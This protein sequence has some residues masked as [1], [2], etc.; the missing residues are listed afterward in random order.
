MNKIKWIF[1][2]VIVL[3]VSGTILIKM[4]KSSQSS[5]K[6]TN[7]GSQEI[8]QVTKVAD[9]FPGFRTVQIGDRTWM[10]ENLNVKTDSSWCY[11]NDEANC[12]KYGRLYTFHDARKACPSGWHL[13]NLRDEKDL[14]RVL[15]EP[16]REKRGIKLAS[17]T[18]GVS[19]FIHNNTVDTTY[20]GTDDLGLS[21]LPGGFSLKKG[22]VFKGIGEESAIWIDSYTSKNTAVTLQIYEHEYTL[23]S[24]HTKNYGLY[25]RC[26]KNYDLD[27]NR[28]NI[29]KNL[30]DEFIDPATVVKETFHDTRDNST[31]KIVTIGKQTWFAENLRYNTGAPCAEK[32]DE[33][34]RKY[35]RAYTW[36]DAMDACPPG[37]R[38]PLKEEFKNL[39]IASGDPKKLQSTS[40]W[41]VWKGVDQNS[42]DDYGMSIYP[43][44]N[45]GLGPYAV[46][47][48]M[49]SKRQKYDKAYQIVVRSGFSGYDNSSDQYNPVRCIKDNTPS[50]SP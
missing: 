36:Y 42:T 14:M 48:T 49:S 31:Y 22:G 20:Y 18:W 40:E 13:A 25:A 2:A 12:K 11:D 6:P 21:F 39:E 7:N 29:T 35:G 9:E 3:M 37:W 24:E 27:C 46:F 45:E 19:K 5:T 44:T 10:A 47:W 8:Q 15:K 41:G 34:C 38:L 30:N 33:G 1:L 50:D 32:N 4:S 26:V 43:V 16:D 28:G 23:G 17:K